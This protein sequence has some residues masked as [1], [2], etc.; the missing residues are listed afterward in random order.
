MWRGRYRQAAQLLERF[1]A[2]VGD[3]AFARMHLAWAHWHLKHVGTVRL[4][5]V[6]ATELMP[7]HAPAW[8]FAGKLMALRDKWDDAERFLRHALHLQPDNLVAASWLALVLLQT[9]REREGIGLLQQFPVADDPY[10]QARLVLHLERLVHERGERPPLPPAQL[11]RWLF[12]PAVRQLVGWLLRWRG[13]RLLEDGAFDTA[14]QWL[15]AAVQLRPSDV[16][17]KVLGAIALLEGG[18]WTQAEQLL[19]QVPETL[20]ERRIAL[21]ALRVRQRQLPEGVALFQD[22]D[23]THPLVRYYIGLARYFQGETERAC[24]AYLEPLYRDDPSALRV[25]LQEL[26]RWLTTS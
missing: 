24:I 20:V 13:E 3:D 22:A 6:R 26:L 7:H 1:L 2:A 15:N 23:L 8:V 14:A 10:L 19:A 9:R 5:A 17:A 25:R 12:V 21:G 4:H 18:H 11:P 16:W